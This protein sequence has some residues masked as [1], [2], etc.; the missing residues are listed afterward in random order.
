MDGN[1]RWAQARGLE[2]VEGHLKGVEAVRTTIESAVRCGVKV[3]T[4]YAFST[5][6]WGRPD[7]EVEAL[8]ELL[9]RCIANEAPELKSKGVRMQFIGDLSRFTPDMQ[10]KIDDAVVLTSECERLTLRIALNYSSRDEIR[11][12]VVGI[13]EAVKSG[14]I[15]VEQ[16][17]EEMIGGALDTKGEGDPDLVIRTSGEQRLSNFMLWQISYAELYFTPLC[18]PDFTAEAF[19]EA[20]E[21]YATRKRRFGLV[22]SIDNE[23]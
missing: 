13:A 11:R 6:N 5:E 19:D 21:V 23:E 8:M 3:L 1:G 16:I 9:G 20:M 4:L 15:E 14:E 18:W 2:R 12:A 22:E 10:Q 7:A 17:S